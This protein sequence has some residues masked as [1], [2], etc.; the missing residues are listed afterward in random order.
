MSKFYFFFKKIILSL[1]QKYIKGSKKNFPRDPIY[2]GL[3]NNI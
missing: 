3:G 2:V 1:L